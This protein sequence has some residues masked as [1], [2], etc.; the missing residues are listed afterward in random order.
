MLAPSELQSGGENALPPG[1]AQGRDTSSVAVGNIDVAGVVPD[2]CRSV[3]KIIIPKEER[4]ILVACGV[5]VDEDPSSFPL[6]LIVD[7]RSQSPASNGSANNP[8]PVMVPLNYYDYLRKVHEMAA[9]NGVKFDVWM[10][11][12]NRLVRQYGVDV[13]RDILTKK[14]SVSPEQV[15]C[16]EKLLKLEGIRAAVTRAIVEMLDLSSFRETISPL[17]TMMEDSSYREGILGRVNEMM[18][19]SDGELTIPFFPEQTT[20]R[21]VFVDALRKSLPRHRRDKP[22]FKANLRYPATEAAV[23]RQSIEEGG[24][25]YISPGTG[26]MVTLDGGRD[27]SIASCLREAACQRWIRIEGD[28]VCRTIKQ[29]WDVDP[30]LGGLASNPNKSGEPQI[31]DPYY[32]IS[33]DLNPASTERQL[34]RRI[35]ANPWPNAVLRSVLIGDNSDVS[36]QTRQVMIRMVGPILRRYLEVASQ[37]ANPQTR[38]LLRAHFGRN[39]DEFDEWQAD[40]NRVAPRQIELGKHTDLLRGMCEEVGARAR[41]ELL[42][43]GT[44]T[45]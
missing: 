27:V 36:P 28:E 10:A 3:T 12:I 17:D 21:S 2:D 43:N 29:N 24:R 11:G 33:H 5:R 23:V 22:D 44:I 7:K 35:I 30:G 1:L 25:R 4:N 14:D 9:K 45:E 42:K 32:V 19:D 26:D 37:N 8:V 6:N 38:A 34:P 39:M 13:A 40:G 20:S 16:L 15:H 41:A 31:V 18:A